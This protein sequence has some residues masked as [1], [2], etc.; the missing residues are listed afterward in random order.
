MFVARDWDENTE[1]KGEKESENSE[2]DCL[3]LFMIRLPDE[4]KN[5]LGKDAKKLAFYGEELISG[6][7]QKKGKQQKQ[8]TQLEVKIKDQ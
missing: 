1:E 3:V 8:V 7:K 4:V 2:E 6:N 5:I